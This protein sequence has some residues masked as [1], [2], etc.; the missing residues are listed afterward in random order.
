[1][2]DR[3]VRQ[4][5]TANSARSSAEPTKPELLADGGEDEVGVLLGDVGQVGLLAVEQALAGDAARSRWRLGLVEVVGRALRCRRCGFEEGAQPVELV[6]LQHAELDHGDHADDGR[7]PLSSTRWRART[8]ATSSIAMRM[9][10][11]TRAVPRS[12]CGRSA[13][14]GR[15]AR[16]R[17]V[18]KRRESS[19]PRC[20]R[21]V[22]RQADDHRRAWRTP[23]AGA[24]TGRA[25]TTPARPCCSTPSGEITSEQHARSCR[26]RS[27]GAKSRNTR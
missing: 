2:A 3:Q 26:R 10:T 25:G 24:G 4:T 17:M 9:A 20:G 18:T 1:M 7:A 23:T 5:T 11:N 15:P 14:S 13:P 8:P 6:L 16:A 27:A 19:S 22:G 21:A 12:G